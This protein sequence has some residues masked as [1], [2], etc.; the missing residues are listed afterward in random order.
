MIEANA[1]ADANYHSRSVQSALIEWQRVFRTLD[2]DKLPGLLADDVTYSNPAEAMPLRGKQ[3]LVESMRL[4]F[5]IFENFEY[6]RQF[7]GEDGHVMEFRGS[8]GDLAF[9]GIDI[10]R[11][12][13]AGKVTDLVVMIRPVAAVLKLAQEEARRMATSNQAAKD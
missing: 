3:A 1:A 12:N 7:S 13:H 8:V 4:S 2:W 9:T 6:A 11:L 5:G 10:I